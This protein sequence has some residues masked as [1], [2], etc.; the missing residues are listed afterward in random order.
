MLAATTAWL[1]DGDAAAFAGP[2]LPDLNALFG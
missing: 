2:P 1:A